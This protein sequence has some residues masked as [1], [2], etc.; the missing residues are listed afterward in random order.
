MRSYLFLL[1]FLLLCFACKEKARPAESTPTRPNFVV[2]L[3]DD[4]GYGDIGAFASTVIQTPRLD[5]LAERGIKLTSCYSG[6]PVCSPSRAALMTGRNPYRSGIGNWIPEDSGVYLDT[7]ETTLPE[8]LQQAGYATGLM[9]KWHL[10]SRVDGSEPGPREHGFEY[11]FYTQN[12][13]YPT[14]QNPTNFIRQGKETGPLIGNS[15]TIAVDTAL[16]WIG[17]QQQPF[18][19]FI[20]LHAPHEPIATPTDWQNQYQEFDDSTKRIYYGSVSLIDHS[21]GRILDSLEARG[22]AE[23]TVLLFTSDNGPET[24]N[25][26]KKAFR[27]HGSPGPL[28][29]MKLHITEAGYR[30][31]GILYWPGH[32][33]A[34]MICD[35]PV[36]GYDLL[37]TFAA[38]AGAEL[39]DDLHLDGASFLPILEGKPIARQQ[40][41]YWQYDK[42]MTPWKISLRDGKWK[43]LAD[44]ELSRF[45]LY[46]LSAD[47]G[48]SN[49]LYASHPEVANRLKAEMLRLHGEINGG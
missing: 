26:Y 27:S 2:I 30:V 22:L 17:R 42:A 45:E 19:A 4:L 46:D 39:P 21:V 7:A 41:L 16:S 20:T 38:L 49:D 33:Q 25:R 37:P 10:N 40:P 8:L 31:P 47:I 48:E 15:T 11:A 29:G 35:E 1:A 43:L 28:R 34:G 18:A 44:K 6:S 36:A 32:T 13:A 3:C 9:G 5:N 12:N 23:N 24:L 14:H